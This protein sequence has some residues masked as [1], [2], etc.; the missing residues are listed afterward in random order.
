MNAELA[1]KKMK[2]GTALKVGLW[3]VG[4]YFIWTSGSTL[5]SYVLIHTGAL[6]LTPEQ[7]QYRQS[8]SLFTVVS[9]YLLMGLNLTG[10]VLLLL[11]YRLAFYLLLGSAAINILFFGFNLISN[12]IVPGVTVSQ[13]VVP[14]IFLALILA[15]VFVL[16]R[17][18]VLW[19]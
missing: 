5:L 8:L 15:F 9:S 10:G 11:R 3:I 19:R 17:K 1:E 18:G 6:V 12:G 13:V 14:Y 4:I 16:H 7:E 2:Y